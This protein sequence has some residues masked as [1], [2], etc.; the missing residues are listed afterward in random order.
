[1]NEVSGLLQNGRAQE[2]L[3]K[4]IAFDDALDTPLDPQDYG[5][6]ISYRFRAAFMAG[7]FEQALR[8]LQYGPARYPA[9][10]PAGAMA[11]LYSMGVEAATKLGR[12]DIAV[13]LADR[14]LELRREYGSREEVL[15]A[16][17]TAATLL[18]GI[19]RRDLASKYLQILVDEGDG[20]PTPGPKQ[21]PA[22]QCARGE[23]ADALLAAGRPAD[24][25]AAYRALIAD[26]F[27]TKHPD[28]VIVGKS[29]LGLLM[30]LIFDNKL[31]EAHAVWIDEEGQT[32]L[33]ILALEGGQTSTHD[34]IAYN[35]VQAYLYSLA[36]SDR[37]SAEQAVNTLMTRCVAY[38]L[39][40]DRQ[41]VPRMVNN[42]RRHVR[43][44]YDDA[45]PPNA[46]R[47][48]EDAENRWGQ[49]V[50]LGP[51]YWARPHPWVVDWL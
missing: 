23:A 28:L 40:R 48:V 2:A 16:A 33:G 12:A 46:L 5:W 35:L 38:A 34:L 1:M 4:L 3:S 49:Q 21:P 26:A 17:K 43:E 31:A 29:V 47:G 19:E 7:D 50:P 20:V 25:A 32:R 9:D 36:A 30:S 37:A 15:M 44:L 18:T 22:E 24:A 13:N 11:T 41:L 51:L 6:I 14:C 39:E 27:A 42:W 10:I 8:V 45:P